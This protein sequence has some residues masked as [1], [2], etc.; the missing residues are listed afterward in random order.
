M[1]EGPASFPT[2]IWTTILDARRTRGPAS[3]ECLNT[4]ITL[5]WRPVYGLLRLEWNQPP[6]QAADL[7]QEFFLTLLEHDFLKDIDPGKGRFRSFVRAALKHFMLN[8]IK[9]RR[10]QKRGGLVKHAAFDVA[11]F[12]G[13]I[14]ASPKTTPDEFFE[15]QWRM[16]VL[17]ES[18]R[19]LKAELDRQKQAK[20]FEVFRMYELDAPV[21]DSPTYEDVAAKVGLV[22][23]DVKQTL[24]K[25]RLLFRKCVT[26]VLRETST[27]EAEVA[28]E[29]RQ[30]A[31]G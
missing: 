18:L 31:G 11:D 10:A 17:A 14:A 5:Y 7:T 28:E 15:T 23:A 8:W 27:S 20:A 3:R 29:L 21:G 26:E 12:E 13:R 6:E 30:L 25:T 24:E 4:L 2:T 22:R 9:A 16:S 1:N 19:R